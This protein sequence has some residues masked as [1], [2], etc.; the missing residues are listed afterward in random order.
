M[1]RFKQFSVS[2]DRSS[3]KVGTDGVLLGA[4]VALNGGEQNILD[5]GTGS[6]LIALMMAQRT[7]NALIDG[8]EIEAQSAMQ[9]EENIAASN[10]SDRV[11]VHHTDIQSFDAGRRY[12]LIVTNPPYFIE[13]LL[14]PDAG[15]T[16]ARHTTELTFAELIK[17]TMRLI[18]PDGRLSLILP[19]AESRIFDEEAEGRLSLIRRCEVYGREG[20]VAKRYISE[21]ALGSSP[22]VEE[23]LVIEG[24]KRGDYTSEYRELTREFYLKF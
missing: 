2:D 15:R 11:V 13:S 1:F 8:V 18:K 7:D 21:Y 19:T 9:A 10:W 5:I 24:D 3:M 6:G 14:S 4:W 20:L 23:R 12:D 17:A 16:T 22:L